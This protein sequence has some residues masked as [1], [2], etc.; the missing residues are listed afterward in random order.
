MTVFEMKWNP[1]KAN[2]SI[3]EAFLKAYDVKET[4]IITPD[5]YLDYLL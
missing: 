3:P 1:K 2:T 5:N 4:V